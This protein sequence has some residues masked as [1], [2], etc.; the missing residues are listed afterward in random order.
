MGEKTEQLTGVVVWWREN[1]GSKSEAMLP[2]L[3][4]GRDGESVAL[5]LRNDNPFENNGLAPYDGCRVAVWGARDAHGTFV[6]DKICQI[7]ECDTPNLSNVS[8]NID[9]EIHHENMPEMQ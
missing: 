4:G 7:S 6:V 1:K 5:A 9:K 8:E 2:H 3:Y